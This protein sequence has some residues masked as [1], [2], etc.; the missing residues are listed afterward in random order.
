[1]ISGHFTKFM[2][3]QA[4]FLRR[5]INEGNYQ[6]NIN[7]TGF[8]ANLSISNI[9]H[10][11]PCTSNICWASLHAA[12]WKPCARPGGAPGKILI[13]C[14]SA[15]SNQTWGD[16]P[17]NLSTTG[18]VRPSS[19]APTQPCPKH[20]KHCGH[21]AMVAHIV[22]AVVGASPIAGMR[23]KASIAGVACLLVLRCLDLVK[24]PRQSGSPKW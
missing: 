3:I 22:L 9:P 18:H 21:G 10:D 17:D 4:H 19:H 13:I 24:A 7:V 2:G 20:V 23:P 5:S 16:N 11:S 1:M 12:I 6:S 8:Q 15:R 14:Q